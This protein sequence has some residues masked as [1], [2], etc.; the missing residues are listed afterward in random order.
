MDCQPSGQT[1][2][3]IVSVTGQLLVSFFSLSIFHPLWDAISFR[4]FQ[5]LFLTECIFSFQIKSLAAGRGWKSSAE[6]F[7]G[8]PAHAVATRKFLC[9]ERHL[10]TQLR[11]TS[12]WVTSQRI[13]MND[14]V[15]SGCCFNSTECRLAACDQD[16]P[17]GVGFCWKKKQKK[18]SN[19]FLMKERNQLR[20]NASNAIPSPSRLHENLCLRISSTNFESQ[21]L[22][23]QVEIFLENL[24]LSF[25][26]ISKRGESGS[27]RGG[28]SR[29]KEGCRRVD[30]VFPIPTDEKSVA[31]WSHRARKRGADRN[32]F[33]RDPLLVPPRL[34]VP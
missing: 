20:S 29:L 17:V 16:K 15:R 23:S 24:P 19:N 28:H 22:E 6:V 30:D 11:L 14:L 34:Y 1:G 4:V 18:E 10:Q 21:V 32:A 33:R 8:F 26:D 25:A 3:I 5:A 27:A 2:G 12:V 7:S 13:P 9:L 31:T